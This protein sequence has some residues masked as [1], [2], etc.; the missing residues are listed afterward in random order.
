MSVSAKRRNFNALK[1]CDH[2]NMKDFSYY[3]FGKMKFEKHHYCP[4]CGLHIWRDR[5]WTANQWE[6]FNEDS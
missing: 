2:S 5:E 1:G 3:N 4:D 6:V